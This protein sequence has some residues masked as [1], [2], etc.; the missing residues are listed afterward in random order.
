MQ[1]SRTGESARPHMVAD[2]ALRRTV[3]V[4]GASGV[5]GTALLPRLGAFD[6]LALVH[7]SPVSAPGIASVTGDVRQPMLGL[8]AAAYEQLT[9]RVDAVV[10]CAAVTDFARADGS[11]Q[12]TNI[13]GTQHIVQLAADAG[14]VLLHVSTAF[15]GTASGSARDSAAAGYA[16]SKVA[17]EQVVLASRV[18]TVVLRPSVVIGDSRTGVI[19]A[20]QGL[21]GV[22]GAVLSGT[23]PMVPFDPSWPIDFVPCDLVADAIATVLEQD[24]RSGEFWI[25]AGSSAMRLDEA[26]ALTVDL[27]TELGLAVEPPRF[28]S[29]DLFERLIGPVF[30]DALPPRARRTVQRLH[31]YF[32]TYLCDGHTLPSSLAELTALGAAPLPDQRQ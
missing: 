1:P 9:Q 25:T 22:A 16:A 8:S 30:L 13:A 4:T 28:V 17:A 2:P 14:A 29:P 5:I 32:A 7:R 27:G 10:H 20:F 24:V 6:V 23:V 26:I 11:L 18:P 21:H 12:D 3:L 15:I 19:S 31:E